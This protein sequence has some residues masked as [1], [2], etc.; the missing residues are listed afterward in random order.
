MS[1]PASTAPRPPSPKRRWNA[2]SAWRTAGDRGDLGGALAHRLVAQPRPRRGR[3]AST[4]RGRRGGRRRRR[5]A[6]GPASS[7]AARDRAVEQAGVEEVER[8]NRRPDAARAWSCR[9]AAGPST[10]TMQAALPLTARAVSICAPSR[11]I[12]AAK[13][14]KA[15]LDGLGALDRD[16]RRG[17]RR[18]AR[19]SSSRCGGRGARRSRR[20]RAAARRSRARPGC[21][22]RPR[23]RTPQAASPSAIAASR[24]LSLTRS[25]ASPARRVVPRAQAAA[26]ARIGYSSI[27]R[28]A[29]SAGTSMPASGAARDLERRRPARRRRRRI[30]LAQ[31]RRPSRARHSSRPVRSGLTPTRRGA[32]TSPRPRPPP[33]AE[34]RPRRCRPAPRARRGRELGLA[35]HADRAAAVRP[36]VSISSSAPSWREQALGM[37]ARGLRLDHRGAARRRAGRRAGPRT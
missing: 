20:R 11:F 6:A 19:G 9:S 15:G 21:P 34:R 5:R 33:P 8:R 22:R 17:E 23:P 37:V 12:S 2:S 14:G 32:A 27:M 7:S 1:R 4:A 29:R 16:R 3:P 30:A 18:R 25:S 24:S 35:E 13:P 26:T 28:G 10:A 31:L 36:A